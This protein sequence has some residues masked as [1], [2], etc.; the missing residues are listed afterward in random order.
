M[1]RAFGPW[2]P[3]LQLLRSMQD[4]RLQRGRLCLGRAAPVG[5]QQVGLVQGDDVRA[6]AV[7]G[8]VQ[9]KLAPHG[10]VVRRGVVCSRSPCSATHTSPTLTLNEL[11]LHSRATGSVKTPSEMK[12]ALI[13]SPASSQLIT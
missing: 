4:A 10:Q 3:H 2:E 12:Q 6:R 5:G 13:G 11:A 8:V 9:L 1:R 7:L